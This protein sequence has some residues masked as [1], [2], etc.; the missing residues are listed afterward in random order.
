M[1]DISLRAGR[2]VTKTAMRSLS[3][4]SMATTAAPLFGAVEKRCR[5]T[6]TTKRN[7]QALERK[8]RETVGEDRLGLLFREVPRNRAI[9]GSTSE[10][11]MDRLSAA[12]LSLGFFLFDKRNLKN[13]SGHGGKA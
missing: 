3:S 11:T 1:L 8:T 12:S 2:T 4:R 9:C 13:A 5:T 10:R 7:R 6:T